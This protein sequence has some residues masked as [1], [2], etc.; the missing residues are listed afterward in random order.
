MSGEA[1]GPDLSLVRLVEQLG[2]GDDAVVRQL[3]AEYHVEQLAHEHLVTRVTQGMA[4]GV[5]PGPAG[6]LLK[7]S[8]ALLDIAKARLGLE[9]AGSDGIF[10][11]ADGNG[12]A[13]QI[14]EGSLSRQIMSL[15]GG[16][17][18]IQRNI[19]S[20]RLL[21]MPREW[22]ADRELAYRDVKRNS[23]PTAPR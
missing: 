11:G 2:L 7:L 5:M 14:G 6:S 3:V 4:A 9:V 19:I 8:H 10:K 21:G 12:S 23:M 17:N 13:W 18:E 15:G 1:G 20:E 16:S 22:S